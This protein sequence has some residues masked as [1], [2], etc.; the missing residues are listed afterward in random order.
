MQPVSFQ[1]QNNNTRFN[2]VARAVNGRETDSSRR[3]EQVFQL[4]VIL[5]TRTSLRPSIDFFGAR[6]RWIKHGN[7]RPQEPCHVITTWY[8]VVH[9][10]S[11]IVNAAERSAI[12]SSVG[13]FVVFCVT[14]VS[15]GTWFAIAVRQWSLTI[16][17]IRFPVMAPFFVRFGTK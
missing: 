5:V 1:L 7:R 2:I 10:C 4:N 8:C 12:I 16:D 13:R 15:S 14:H 11:S 3:P 6:S 17:G 9:N